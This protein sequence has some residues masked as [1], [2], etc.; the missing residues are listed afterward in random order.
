MS[1]RRKTIRF[2]SDG[3]LATGL[4][5][6]TEDAESFNR[7]KLHVPSLSQNVAVVGKND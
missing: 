5:E 4:L 7:L 1:D 2:S 6:L 3:D